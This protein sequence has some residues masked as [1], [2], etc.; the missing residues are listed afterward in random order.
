VVLSLA[1][2]PAELWANSFKV[3]LP[4]L[5]GS[6]GTKEK[7]WVVGLYPVPMSVYSIPS[8]STL[9]EVGSTVDETAGNM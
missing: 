6:G 3:W 2:V 8:I 9:I 1:K 7:K 4:L 5:R